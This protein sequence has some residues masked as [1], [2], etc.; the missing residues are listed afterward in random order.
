MNE[1]LQKEIDDLV[2]DREKFN[3]FVYTPLDEAIKKLEKNRLDEEL[4]KK[5]N[6]FIQEGLDDY[7]VHV[8]RA[9]FFFS[10][11]T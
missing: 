11:Y 3:K 7:F 9:I 8:P 5:L 10:T 6:F 1:N 4:G 2:S